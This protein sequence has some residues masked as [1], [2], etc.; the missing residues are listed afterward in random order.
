M[1]VRKA[2]AIGAVGDAMTTAANRRGRLHH[3]LSVGL[4]QK[5]GAVDASALADSLQSLELKPEQ[6]GVNAAS[7]HEAVERM[8]LKLSPITTGVPQGLG[9]YTRRNIPVLRG[10]S[11]ALKRS[12]LPQPGF[13]VAAS[14]TL[15]NGEADYVVG[16]IS[17]KTPYGQVESFVRFMEGM[18]KGNTTQ[19]LP[20]VL[21][22]RP[23]PNM[24]ARSSYG[25]NEST[26]VKHHKVTMKKLGQQADMYERDHPTPPDFSNA[27]EQP[28]SNVYLFFRVA[29]GKGRE[30]NYDK[31]A[32]LAKHISLGR[33]RVVKYDERSGQAELKPLDPL[34]RVAAP[35][36]SDTSQDDIDEAAAALA[37]LAASAQQ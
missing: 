7:D 24:G 20:N 6:T 11:Y 27:D 8:N 4:L 18:S 32:G 34:R 17:E 13:F 10:Q 25:T 26:Y 29:T 28:F 1:S 2:E 35:A 33:F 19:D 23:L 37:R 9:W 3:V 14:G 12:Q 16:L 15:P 22:T 21:Y 36:P 30:Q 31:D 5:T